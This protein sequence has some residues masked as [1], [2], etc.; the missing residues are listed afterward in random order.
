MGSGSAP[1]VDEALVKRKQGDTRDLSIPRNHIVAI[2]SA[3]TKSARTM[4][5]LHMLKKEVYSFRQHK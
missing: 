1:Y 3:I 5:R 2:K 4:D